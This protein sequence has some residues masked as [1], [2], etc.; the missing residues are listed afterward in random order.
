MPTCEVSLGSL[1]L[2]A[3]EAG[4][5]VELCLLY[6]FTQE[7]EEKKIS[8]E[9]NFYETVPKDSFIQKTKL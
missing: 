4:D 9:I 5:F 2:P 1:P 6:T 3:S 8:S 7:I